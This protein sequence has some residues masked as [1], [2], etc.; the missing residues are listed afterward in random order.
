[1]SA[2]ALL[3]AALKVAS[4][5]VLVLVLV[6]IV[7]Y[8]RF[9]KSSRLAD[10]FSAG[11]LNREMASL[12][13]RPIIVLGDSVLWGYGIEPEQTALAYLARESGSWRNLSF[14]GGSP[15]N[16][17]AML[18][19]LTMHGVHPVAIVFNVNLKEFNAAD[20]AYQKLYPAVECLSWNTLAPGERARLTVVNR[21]TIDARVNRGVESVW[22]L[23]GMRSE[24][25]DALFGEVDAA[26]ALQDAVE[27]ASGTAAR[28]AV[29]HPP[30]P[31]KFEGTYDLSPLDDSNV[32]VFFLNRLARALRAQGIPGYAILT[33]TN[34]RLL[35]EYIDVPEYAAQLGYLKRTLLARHMHVLDYDRAFAPDEF[36]DNDHLTVA[37]NAHLATLLERDVTP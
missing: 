4:T 23:Y 25:R 9:P 26:H 31:E 32:E 6:D 28:R 3:G 13:S 2:S 1:M 10:S 19:L 22:Q 8:A 15:A 37:G 5:A 12:R 27:R 34:H 30:A 29:A 18:R 11:Y 20:S 35:H 24:V 16:S 14:A 7:F 17:Y 33:P 36:I 21:Q